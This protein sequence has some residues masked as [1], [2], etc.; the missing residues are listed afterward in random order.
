MLSS[1]MAKPIIS[2]LMQVFAYTQRPQWHAGP[3]FSIIPQSER[4]NIG[5]FV[6]SPVNSDE[7]L[8]YYRADV[9]TTM[10]L[11]WDWPRIPRILYCIAL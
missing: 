2:K 1:C 8:N 10:W 9:T 6:R 7:K 4:T 11:P 5:T 3:F